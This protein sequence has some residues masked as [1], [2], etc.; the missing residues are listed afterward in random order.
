MN[1]LAASQIQLVL[2]C[3]SK[4]LDRVQGLLTT[5]EQAMLNSERITPQL[6]EV[7]GYYRD[8]VTGLRKE[9]I[10]LCSLLTSMYRREVYEDQACVEMPALMPVPALAPILPTTAPVGTGTV[11]AP[12]ETEA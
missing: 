11:L 12:Q 1:Q 10:G 4:D 5:Y 6:K 9:M 2:E 8:Q 7:V 3:V